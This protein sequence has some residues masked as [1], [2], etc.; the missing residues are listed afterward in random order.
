MGFCFGLAV[1]HLLSRWDVNNTAT[2][3]ACAL[4]TGPTGAQAIS[5]TSA[6]LNSSAVLL[7]WSAPV[8]PN[9]LIARYEV[10]RY[11]P[12]SYAVPVKVVTVGENQ[13]AV[14]G[15]RP[16]TAYR[17]TVRA[18]NSFA[19]TGHSGFTET[20]TRASGKRR[21]GWT[22]STLARRSVGSIGRYSV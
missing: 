17:F 6:E 2:T 18:C 8:T 3:N 16:Y 11:D 1:Y 7:T 20:R 12:P 9:G 15:L 10:Y 13:T 4:F 21:T 19:C 14:G 22:F 5:P